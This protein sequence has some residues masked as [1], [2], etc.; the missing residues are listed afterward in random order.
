MGEMTLETFMT[1]VPVQAVE[2]ERTEDG[3]V[4]LLRPKFTSPRLAWLQKRLSRPHFRVRL[5]RRGSYIWEA[6]DG[7]RTVREVCDA[8]RAGL[9]A[10]AEPVEER[11]V[12]FLHHLL[13]GRFLRLE[14]PKGE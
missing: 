6:V 3:L 4:V 14:E 9:G 2:S 12:A 10:E 13:S 5:D 1:W 8:L 7:R 11:A